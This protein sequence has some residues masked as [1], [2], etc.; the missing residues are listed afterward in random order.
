MYVVRVLT[1]DLDVQRIPD[2]GQALRGERISTF[3]AVHLKVMVVVDCVVYG[4]LEG[5]G[6]RGRGREREREKGGM[7]A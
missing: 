1:R 2:Q 4:K 5:E 3:I 6:G 7:F